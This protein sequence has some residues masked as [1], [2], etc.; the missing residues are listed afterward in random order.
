MMVV[1]GHVKKVLTVN[2]YKKLVVFSDPQ[3]ESE[4]TGL[5]KQRVLLPTKHL[6]CI[7]YISGL[8]EQL[9]RVFK[10]HSI[11]SYHKP[12]NTIRSLLVNPKDKSK[13]ETQCGVVYSIKCSE[14]GQEYQ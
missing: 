8:S 13:K 9:Q 12:V 2:E 14:C 3:E 4:G 10:S 11:P 6:V 7:P 5:K 1:A